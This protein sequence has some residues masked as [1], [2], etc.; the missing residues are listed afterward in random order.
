MKIEIDKPCSLLQGGNCCTS[1]SVL[2][3]CL[4]F[5]MS[6]KQNYDGKKIAADNS[7]SNN[8]IPML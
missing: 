4:L 6:L 5:C 2:F 7:N 3:W 1:F 8:P